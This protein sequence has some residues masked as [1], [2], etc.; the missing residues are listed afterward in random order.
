[1]MAITNAV[2]PGQVGPPLAA[3]ALGAAA[4]S[5]VL[6]AASVNTGAGWSGSAC[7]AAA[8][9]FQFTACPSLSVC[10]AGSVIDPCLGSGPAEMLNVSNWLGGIAACG[11]SAFQS[12][13]ATY[14]VTTLPSSSFCGEGRF[15][16]DTVAVQPGL[17]CVATDKIGVLSGRV[18]DNSVVE[19]VSD[20]V[21]TRNVSTPEP[22]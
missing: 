12:T 22:P 4:F 19:A 13:C 7:P 6:L 11:L 20:S 3:E 5:S 1:M 16:L 14:W 9:S 10:D 21:G 2:I 18:T 17:G 8:V 15:F